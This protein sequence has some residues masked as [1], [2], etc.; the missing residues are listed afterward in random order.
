MARQE[1]PVDPLAGPLQSFAYDLRKVRIEAGN[2]TYRSL[3][4]A[5]GYSPTTLSEAAAGL[6][7]P[8]L[9]VVEAYVGACSGDVEAWR[10]R[11]E[12]LD[13]DLAGPEAE[14][15]AEPEPPV[16]PARR[17]WWPLA[18]GGSL[19][20]VVAAAAIVLTLGDPPPSADASGC[21][22]MP[23]HRT[24]TAVTY[25]EGAPVRAAAT[26]TDPVLSTVPSGCT[27]GFTGFCV[28]QRVRDVTGGTPDV[29]WFVLP[30]G[31]V[32]P[33]ALVHGNPPAAL[34][35]VACAKGR[36]VPDGIA[37]VLTADNAKS[38]GLKATASGGN[39]EIVGFAVR[40]STGGWRALGLTEKFSTSITVAPGEQVVVAAAACFGGDGPTGLIDARRFPGAAQ[41]ATLST[42]EYAAASKAACAYP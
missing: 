16:V 6:R 29:R 7:K 41:S 28:G 14:P 3:A 23:S 2:P 19:A 40:R 39:L 8:S 25:G 13:R 36:P 1:N 15:G 21:P 38:G 10:R 33:S 26:L 42:S 31:K 4:K 18:L 5:A 12:Q 9:D 27:L 24:F 37:L 17:H 30:D 35:P 11:W 32:V 34:T 22:A 20:L